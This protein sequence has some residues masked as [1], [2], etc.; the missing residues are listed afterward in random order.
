MVEGLTVR[1]TSEELSEKLEE[2]IAWHEASASDYEQ[3]LRMP[4]RARED[5]DIPEHILAHELREHRE[6]IAV[7]TL[8]RDHLLPD[9][10]Y[11]LSEPD[12]RLADLVPE[13]HMSFVMPSRSRVPDVTN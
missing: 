7:L 10:I 2:R 1:M 8:L 3:E 11:L 5:Q 12:L 4:A 13:L 9:E 6:R